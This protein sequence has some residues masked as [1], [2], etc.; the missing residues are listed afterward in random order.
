M[1]K[2][3][4]DWY[5]ARKKHYSVKETLVWA[6]SALNSA[7]DD[8]A[9][10]ASALANRKKPIDARFFK[11][12]AL[13]DKKCRPMFKLL[14][15]RRFASLVEASSE[16]SDAD[17]AQLW[18][19]V[20]QPFL[21]DW[22]QTISIVD[23]RLPG[24]QQI[25]EFR[26]AFVTISSLQH[27][28]ITEPGSATKEAIKQYMDAFDRLWPLWELLATILP[29][30]SAAKANGAIRG[31]YDKYCLKNAVLAALFDVDLKTISRWKT[32]DTPHAQEFRFCRDSR[33]KM[34]N[35]ARIF[36]AQRDYGRDCAARGRK[37]RSRV[38][39]SEDIGADDE[40]SDS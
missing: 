32:A 29:V 24:R 9:A 11:V 25:I 22:G 33:A 13:S 26:Q 15:P 1:A 5:G 7:R 14:R 35:L 20:F 34:E 17:R 3:N 30:G 37:V 23:N 21:G 10:L 38:S 36:K 2:L 12:F 31:K 6:S 27:Q 40:E 4:D 18:K 28:M 19:T 16:M 39:Y 8:F